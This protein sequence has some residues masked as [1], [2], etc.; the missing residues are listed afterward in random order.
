MFEIVEKNELANNIFEMKVLAPR[1]AQSALPGQFIIVRT[2][3]K[4]ERIPLTICDYDAQAGTVTIV[5]QI[6]GIS[7]Q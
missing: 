2:D 7:S 1:V 6:V 4:G 3:E 5:T